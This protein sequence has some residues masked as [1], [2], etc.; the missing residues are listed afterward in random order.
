M[1]APFEVIGKP[2]RRKED[3]R[4]LTG[5]GRYSDDLTPPGTAYAA[6]VRSPYAHARIVSIDTTAAR[7][8]AGVLGVYTFADLQKDGVKPI[9]PDYA[10]LG[11]P[12]VQR[13]L[14]D[15]VLVNRDGSD[16]FQSPYHLLAADRARFA[17]QSVAMVVAESVQ[18][19]KDAAEAVAVE[20]EPLPAVVETRA[21]MKADAP[22]L[23]DHAPSN[24]TLDAEHGDKAATDA[25]FAKAAHVV[26][27]DTWIQRVTGVPME[28]R[29]AASRW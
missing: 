3:Q 18:K 1:N 16:M 26:K 25:A 4:L 24:I 22:R 27:L 17:G 5:N 12:E 21:A 7:R 6:I 14:P 15:V 10:F 23:W 11:P 2:L 19:A 13:Q 20:Y 9:P 29:S 28:S 8:M